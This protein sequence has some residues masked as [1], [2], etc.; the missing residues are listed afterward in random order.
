[1]RFD[2]DVPNDLQG[3]SDIF[4]DFILRYYLKFLAFSSSFQVATD[5]CIHLKLRICLRTSPT[6]IL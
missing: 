2:P 3:E 5:I 4:S 6:R 1:M